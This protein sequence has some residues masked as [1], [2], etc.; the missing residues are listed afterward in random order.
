M[1]LRRTFVEKG[2]LVVLLVL[3]MSFCLFPLSARAEIKEL[4]IGIGVDADTLNPQEQTTT[5]FQ[6]MCDLMYGNFFYQDPEGKLHP[7][8]A[9]K[10]DVSKDGLTYTLHLRK[11]VKFSDGTDFNADAVKLTWDRILNPQI[12]VPLR[13]AVSMVKECVKIDD[14]TVQLKLK[15]AFA[16]LVPTLSLSIVSPISPAAL[17]KYGEDVRQH[18]VGAGPYIL[19][20][21]VKGDRIV[22]VR[23]ENYWGKKP[24]VAKIVWKVIPEAATREAMLRAGQIQVCYKPLPSNVAALK[25][26]PNITVDMPLD[27]RTIFMGMNCQKGVTKNKLI[28]QAFNYA[29]DKKA[30]VKRILFNT[31][32]PMDGPVSPKLFGYVKM[33]QQYNYNPEKAKELLKKA[34]FDFSHTIHMRTPNGRYLF[35]KQVSEAIQAYVQAIGV[36]VE[37]RTYD[38]PTYVAGLLKPID[39]SELELFLLGWG[40]LVLDADMALYG[41]FACEV[42]P[43]KGLGSAFYCNPAYDK[44]MKASRREQDPQKRFA[45]LKKASEIVWDDCPWIWLHVEKFVVAYSGKIKGMV[46]TPTEK[47]YPTYITM[48]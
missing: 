9:T 30:I 7:R 35:D 47:F 2:L 44:I 40:P 39:Q 12:R 26:D 15:Y 48:E 22:M 36:K 21:W 18:P 10:A 20:E 41:Q 19:K 1:E 45:L 8:L 37:L 6:N 13:F 24:T 33:D 5:L 46:V 34:N 25:A 17:K 32:R 27:T 28:R 11:G 16:P 31:A 23:N 14:Y 3:G 42:N 38:W 43:P 4:K 29:V